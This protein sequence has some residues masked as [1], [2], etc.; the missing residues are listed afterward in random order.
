MRPPRDLKEGS[1]RGKGVIEGR[2][3]KAGGHRQI[4]MNRTIKP[5][6]FLSVNTFPTTPGNAISEKNAPPCLLLIIFKHILQIES[7]NQLPDKVLFIPS[8]LF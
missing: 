5:N 1:D 7:Q 8:Y 2:V 4:K 6:T 3:C